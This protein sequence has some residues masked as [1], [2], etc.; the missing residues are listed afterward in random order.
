MLLTAGWGLLLS[1][2]LAKPPLTTDLLHTKDRQDLLEALRN[3]PPTAGFHCQMTE[4]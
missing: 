2:H 4:S 1:R 3:A